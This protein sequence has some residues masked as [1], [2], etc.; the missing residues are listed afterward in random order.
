MCVSPTGAVCSRS[1]TEEGRSGEEAER[2]RAS[3]A[4]DVLGGNPQ[5]AQNVAG[6][7]PRLAPQPVA[8]APCPVPPITNPS[9]VPLPDSSD[10]AFPSME[11]IL[12][13]TLPRGDFEDV[14][15]Q[16]LSAEESIAGV[17]G[18]L[19]ASL[20]KD[21]SSSAKV[22]RLPARPPFTSQIDGTVQELH[23]MS[24]TVKE[25]TN[26]NS[27]PKQIQPPRQSAEPV[28]ITKEKQ[29]ITLE[30]KTET[31]TNVELCGK[32]PH[33]HTSQC[34]HK[35]PSG[36]A[37][38]A[39]HQQD[40][41]SALP[42]F[43]TDNAENKQTD[44][45]KTKLKTVREILHKATEMHK[46]NS[47]ESVKTFK[48]DETP[49]SA[50]ILEA[51]KSRELS[52][53][54]FSFRKET[55]VS[56]C[57]PL[58]AD[59]VGSNTKNEQTDTTASSSDFKMLPEFSSLKGCSSSPVKGPALSDPNLLV[60]L[61]AET[62]HTLHQVPSTETS[63]IAEIVHSDDAREIVVVREEAHISGSWSNMHLNQNYLL[64]REDGSVC[65]AAIVNEL[66]TGEPKLYEG[67]VQASMELDSQP[68]EVYEFCG[69]V[70]EVAEETVCVGSSMQIPHSPGYEVNLFNALL[71]NADE[72]FEPSIHAVNDNTIIIS[73]QSL[74]SSSD[75]SVENTGVAAVG[76]H[77]VLN[78]NQA[79]EMAHSGEV[80]L[81]QVAAVTSDS[82]AV[83]QTD[84]TTQTGTHCSQVSAAQSDVT[85]VS[86]STAVQTIFPEQEA[87]VTA[88]S[89]SLLSPL[90]TNQ[91]T[92]T[93]SS[94][95]V[96]LHI[97]CVENQTPG[98]T[99]VSAIKPEV[100]SNDGTKVFPPSTP[101]QNVAAATESKPEA[102]CATFPPGLINPS[103]LL[104]KPGETPL[105]KH[106]SSL[107]AK[108]SKQQNVD[109]QLA[110][111]HSSLCGT[112]SEECLPRTIS[113]ADSISASLSSQKD[114]CSVNKTLASVDVEQPASSGFTSLQFEQTA[115]VTPTASTSNSEALT[116]IRMPTEEKD[117][118]PQNLETPPEATSPA[119]PLT[120]HMLP[121]S[122]KKEEPT[123]TPSSI[124][125][126]SYPDDAEDESDDM[127]QDEMAGESEVQDSISGQVSS[128]EEESED[129]PDPDKNDT[130]SSSHK[131]VP[132]AMT[133]SVWVLKRTWLTDKIF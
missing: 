130:P 123:P 56:T 95:T 77:L 108:V 114:E 37:E 121:A 124:N 102:L 71:E 98:F 72:D 87:E 97:S 89:L 113:A 21:C 73:Q 58:E 117:H 65:R 86:G 92:G 107:L 63:L 118:D 35:P 81:V 99:V 112:V 17:A 42:S 9:T 25:K 55:S 43:P 116:F 59:Q 11:N 52:H 3:P 133:M 12:P 34:S 127:E 38:S 51:S 29:S 62:S 16:E 64:Q 14:I 100:C 69:L 54:S 103:L 120:F 93:Q 84:T 119:A 19:P 90:V 88:G 109:I 83:E 4:V 122:V 30:Y 24:Q 128:P 94:S 126:N 8:A 48:Y 27:Q 22:Q 39:S 96:S 15:S 61:Q 82:F 7:S 33:I 68:V 13:A 50:K 20:T 46:A 74:P 32:G 105:L 106:P 78:S 6:E 131:V 79:V 41:K 129:E 47:L 49:H 40:S 2:Q 104:L 76:H 36:A 23:Y 67:S 53:G 132:V 75:M 111:A 85:E 45:S 1:S 28:C 44:Q 110:N 80:C 26:T 125:D 60:S 70:E 57:S 101:S 115:S 91:D 66:S 5:A 18:S 31:G 10:S